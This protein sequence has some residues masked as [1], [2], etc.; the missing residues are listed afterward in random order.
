MPSSFSS[1]IARK[2]VWS[3]ILLSTIVALFSTIVQTY[4]DYRHNINSIKSYL[5]SLEKTYLP[6]IA[7][8]TWLMDDAQIITLLEGITNRNDIV[9]AAIV[10]DDAVRWSSGHKT[11]IDQLQTTL[12]ILYTFHDKART[13]GTLT[14]IADLKQIY[15]KLL[16]HII[17][18]LLTNTVKTFVVAGLALLLVQRLITRHLQTMASQVAKFSFDKPQPPLKLQ[19]KQPQKPDE[20]DAVTDA[21]SSMQKRGYESYN[22]L[23]KGEQRLRLFLDST[24]EGIFGV[25]KNGNILFANAQCLKIIGQSTD[26]AIIGRPMN[27]IFSFHCIS[28]TNPTK[29]DIPLYKAILNCQTFSCED[30]YLNCA[31]QSGFFSALRAYPT[32]SNGTCS[33]SVVFFHDTSDERA[34]QHQ[35]KLLQEA[36]N[37]SPVSILITDKNFTIEYVNPGFEKGSGYSSSEVI[38]KNI[39]IL[40]KEDQFLQKVTQASANISQGKT[41]QGEIQYTNRNNQLRTAYVVASPLFSPSGEVSN[42]VAVSRDITNEVELQEQLII[43]QRLEAMSRLSASIAHEFGNPLIG[44]RSLLK[45]FQE[46]LILSEDDKTLLDIAESECGRMQT[47]IG[48]FQDFY[49]ADKK[50]RTLCD[51]RDA[52]DKVMILHQKIFID[53]SIET[54]INHANELPKL[55]CRKDQI[56]QVILNLIIN[57]VDAMT[58]DGGTLTITT[59]LKVDKISIKIEDTGHGISREDQE[60]IFE[61]FFSTK[62]E[63]E[64]TGLGLPVSFGIVSTH[65]GNITCSSR[66]SVG[67]TFIILLPVREY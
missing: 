59:S 25:D 2:L 39:A 32:Y 3:F 29:H 54:V 51:I 61:P 27:D 24:E 9:Y 4:V 15:R 47:L 63:V 10:V 14:V 66:K 58:P 65:G 5:S 36:M 67:S 53:Q 1:P 44:I 46:R 12:P 6:S 11:N 8:N 28:Q 16:R 31:G 50:A 52:I 60:H 13:I 34:M 41:W 40:S 30:S 21:L 23:A 17:I 42:L 48:D 33:G 22:A 37:N 20:L 26:H 7:K 43:T 19:R 56:T 35:M 18:V 64:G 45:D 55:F 62:P 49:G 38:G 57:A